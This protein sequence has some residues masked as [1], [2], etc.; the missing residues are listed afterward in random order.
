[1]TDQTSNP[2]APHDPA[3]THHD[4]MPTDTTAR[5]VRSPE[6]V[7]R[8][9]VQAVGLGGSPDDAEEVYRLI[10]ARDAEVRAERRNFRSVPE[11]MVWQDYYS[12]D[13][14][15]QIR[16]QSRAEELAG[17]T[18]ERKDIC[19]NCGR[20]PCYARCRQREPNPQRRLVGPWEPVE[21]AALLN[22]PTEG[23]TK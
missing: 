15:T 1:M 11:G 4:P 13:E 12:P 16:E 3:P 21:T 9:I 5:V 18:E 6:E 19:G 17:F 20:S 2:A 10:R 23:E 14:V 8:E 7:A 22:P